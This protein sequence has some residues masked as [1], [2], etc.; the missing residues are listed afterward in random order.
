MHYVSR[1]DKAKA[2]VPASY[3]QHSSGF[4]R[5]T[6]VERSIGSVHM[7]VGSEPVRWIE[8]Q[9]PL[10]PAKEVFRFERDWTHL[11]QRKQK[12]LSITP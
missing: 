11:A 8:S 1:V 6:Y 12:G 9:A 7:D 4:R 5:S 2:Q 3:A 10:P